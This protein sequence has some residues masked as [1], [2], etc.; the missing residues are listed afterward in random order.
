MARTR[1]ELTGLPLKVWLTLAEKAPVQWQT[2]FVAMVRA[3]VE[4]GVPEELAE[5]Q[6]HGALRGDRFLK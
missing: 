5:L 4:V 1:R 6:A 3:K 2:E